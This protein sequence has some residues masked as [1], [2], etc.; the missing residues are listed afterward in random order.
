MLR[1]PSTAAGL[2]AHTARSFTNHNMDPSHPD[3]LLLK[4][5]ICKEQIDVYKTLVRHTENLEAN[6]EQYAEQY[7]EER[8]DADL[9]LEVAENDQFA[10]TVLIPM[11]EDIRPLQDVGE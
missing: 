3:T 5:S 8:E 1:Q 11:L 2:V 9:E 4:I 7:Q 10:A 6:A